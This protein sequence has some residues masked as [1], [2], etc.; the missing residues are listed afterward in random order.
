MPSKPTMPRGRPPNYV[1]GRNG[2]PITGLS[3]SSQGR[4]YATHSN[5]RKTF[6]RDFDQAV[7]R[8]RHWEATQRG[9]ATI[10][11]P[12]IAP[13]IPEVIQDE[14][15]AE[16]WITAVEAS[17]PTPWPGNV[18]EDAFYATVRELILQ[19]PVRFAERVGIPEIG[20][21]QDVPKPTTS[22]RL[23]DC[24]KEYEGKRKKPSADEMRKVRQAWAL[25]G[26]CVKPAKRLQDVRE[27]EFTKWVDRVFLEYEDGDGSPK[28]VHHR[29]KR[30]FTVLNYCKRR[31]IDQRNCDRLLSSIR[32]VELPD[33][34]HE[35]PN[36]ITRDEFHKLLDAAEGTMWESMLVVMLNLCYYPIDIRTLSI[37]AINLDT[38]VVMFQRAKKRT[39]RVGILWE[40]ARALLRQ[41]MD[42]NITTEHVYLSNYGTPFTAQGLRNSF[43]R[44]RKKSGLGPD[45][46]MD[47]IRDGAY[48]A[49]IQG[50]ESEKQ[51]KI[52]AGHRFSGETDA[53]V[54][55]HPRMVAEAC[56]AIEKFYFD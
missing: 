42:S 16:G 11:L 5:P 37:D 29:L 20:H 43:R 51:A 54:K 10:R 18:P 1:K 46:I 38:G 45:V 19:D 27:L 36:P 53:Y 4:Y 6:G 34:N 33:L 25:F 7:M 49:A 17:K 47:R 56:K 50:T 15:V 23:P 41:W 40:R 39:T 22:V 44:L 12:H 55:R 26:T 32:A 8:F 28:T 31:E 9:K 24:L 14:C 21:L 35:N 13:I 48:T 52:I 2:K 30:V 3:L